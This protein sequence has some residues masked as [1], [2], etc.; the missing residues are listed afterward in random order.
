MNHTHEHHL[1][2]RAPQSKSGQSDKLHVI[3]VISNPVRFKSRYALFEKFKAHMAT[4]PLVEF[5]V[6][7]LAQGRRPFEITE[8]CNPKHL[9]L[10]SYEELWFKENMI[11][12]GIS[13]LPAD[14][15]SVA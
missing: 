5:H 11:N 3:E 9:Q 13:R 2:T 15:N 1:S 7:E 8:E 12:L 10:R 6:V 4:Q 14:W